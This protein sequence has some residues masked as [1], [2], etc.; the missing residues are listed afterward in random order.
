[1]WGFYNQNELKRRFKQK[2]KRKK[3]G[4]THEKKEIGFRYIK[5]WY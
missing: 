2:R 5:L 1:M 4:S 3:Q